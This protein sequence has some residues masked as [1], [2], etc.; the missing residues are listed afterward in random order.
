MIL[1]IFNT[2][3][4]VTLFISLPYIIGWLHS[5][6]FKGSEDCMIA[7]CILYCGMVVFTFC[8]YY[9]TLE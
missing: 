9:E 4:L 3:Q 6:K 7:A 8:A 2:V 1:K 5:A